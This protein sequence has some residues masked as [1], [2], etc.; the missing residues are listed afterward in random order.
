MQSVVLQYMKTVVF[1][2]DSVSSYHS[3]WASRRPQWCRIRDSA[4][5]QTPPSHQLVSGHNADRFWGLLFRAN[6][7]MAKEYNL[8]RDKTNA[9]SP[10]QHILIHGERGT[11]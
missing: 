11:F 7:N 9:Q 5:A 1:S 6:Q 8:R 2:H 3:N 4:H 10:S